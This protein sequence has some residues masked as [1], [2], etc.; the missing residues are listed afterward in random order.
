[1]TISCNTILISA[2]SSGIGLVVAKLFFENND[3]VMMQT[4][5]ALRFFL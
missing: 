2:G 1:M 4:I 5:T 3:Q